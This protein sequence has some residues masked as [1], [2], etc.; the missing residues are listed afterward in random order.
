MS[1]FAYKVRGRGCAAWG[2]IVQSRDDLMWIPGRQA[3]DWGARRFLISNG[4]Q[5]HFGLCSLGARTFGVTFTSEANGD[6]LRLLVRAR[7]FSG[8]E[9]IVSKT[10]S[11]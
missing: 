11:A 4:D 3:S 2:E 7:D 10:P 1:S 6:E 9:T 8:F 5:A